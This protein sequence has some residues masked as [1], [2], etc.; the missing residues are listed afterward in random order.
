MGAHDFVEHCEGDLRHAAERQQQG[1]CG[2]RLLACVE[3]TRIRERHIVQ[4]RACVCWGEGERAGVGPPLRVRVL[5]T[6]RLA[7]LSCPIMTLIPSLNIH[8]PTHN[9]TS[10]GHPPGQAAKQQALLTSC[11][12]G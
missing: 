2:E 5:V 3:S 7:L 9:V 12:C 8:P 1:E 11:S 6:S 4:V 10:A